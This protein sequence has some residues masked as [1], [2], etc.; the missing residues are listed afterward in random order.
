[1]RTFKI[2]LDEKIEDK[3]IGGIMTWKQFLVFV[4]PALIGFGLFSELRFPIWL[5]A[6]LEIFILVI[7]SAFAFL[8]IN[9]DELDVFLKKLYKFY[10]GKRTIL[11][12]SD[13]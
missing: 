8:K 3:V 2:P 1:M 7:G 4:V 10:T 6:I 5:A 9:G 12:R 13:D 11:Y